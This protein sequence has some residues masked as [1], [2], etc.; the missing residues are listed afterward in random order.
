MVMN[1]HEYKTFETERLI[2][3]PMVE[4]DAEFMCLLMNTPKWLQYIGDKNV[5]SPEAAGFYIRERMLP[6][7]AQAGFSTYAVIRKADDEKIGTCGLY[8][9]RGIDGYDIGFAFFPAYEKQ[10]Y[11]YEATSTLLK[12]AFEVF[13]LPH[14]SAVVQK[15]NIASQRLLDKLGLTRIGPVILPSAMEEIWHY[16]IDKPA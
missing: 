7:L 3:R 16:R 13:H 9:R 12:A 15:D 1:M 14:I 4:A 6:Q 2:L 5:R 8:D 10:G 11:A